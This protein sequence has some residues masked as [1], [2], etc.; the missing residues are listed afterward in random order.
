MKSS[1]KRKIQAELTR[2]KGVGS[3]TVAMFLIF[4]LNR[5]RVIPS[6][7]FGIRKAIKLLYDLEDL[8]SAELVE[9]YYQAWEPHESAVSWYLW[10]SL[11]N[12]DS[13]VRIY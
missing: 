5:P 7:D 1:I 13:K 6:G 11:E 8:P 12:V 9:K 3:W 2:I 10:R 4:A